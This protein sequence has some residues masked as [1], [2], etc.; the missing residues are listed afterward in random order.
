MHQAEYLTMSSQAL[1]ALRQANQVRHVR[2]MLKAQVA[3]GQITAA[4]VILTCPAE[5]RRMPIAQ[6]LVSQ[7][8]WGSGRSAAFLA[9]VSVFEE[10]PIGSLTDRQRR[11]I[12]SRLSGTTARTPPG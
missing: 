8:G 4:E 7:R 6:L 5:V 3:E 10:K 11:T 1:Q 2:S 9:E 12:A